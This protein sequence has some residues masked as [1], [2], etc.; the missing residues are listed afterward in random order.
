MLLLLVIGSVGVGTGWACISYRRI[1]VCCIDE[2]QQHDTL[3]LKASSDQITTQI[4]LQ[5]KD[6][7]LPRDGT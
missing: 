7:V 6:A 5:T 4:L 2:N 1:L 3:D